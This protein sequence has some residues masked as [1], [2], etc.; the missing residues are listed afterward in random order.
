MSTIPLSLCIATMNRWEFLQKNI[1]QYLEN[2]F[3]DE[4]VICD[5]TGEDAKHIQETWP[6]NPKIRVYIN[7]KRLHAFYNKQKVC[8][9]AKNDWI[10]L[11]DSD[12]FAPLTYFKA[13]AAYLR[14]MS[15][16]EPNKKVIYAPSGWIPNGPVNVSYNHFVNETINIQTANH[17]YH[18]P[19]G[20]CLFNNG[21]YIFHKG[22]LDA[23]QADPSLQPY[24]D[25]CLALDVCMQN[26]L[27]L[28]KGG[29]SIIVVPGMLYEHA[30][31][32]GSYYIQTERQLNKGI[33][34][35]FN[36]Y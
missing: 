7:E 30:L 31:H 23:S 18:Q 33:P 24:I 27:F 3:I 9:L 22:L 1:P 15:G 20:D 5:E 4:I 6:D 21:N 25:S 26:Y 14:Q 16:G 19:K 17:L 11:M 35:L 29:A 32:G 12:N 13:W 34:Q 28:A 2:P 36:K 8:S 10:C